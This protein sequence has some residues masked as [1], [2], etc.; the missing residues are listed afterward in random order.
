[1]TARKAKQDKARR[2]RV[3][4]VDCGELLYMTEDGEREALR[5]GEWIEFRRK[6]T[7][8]D[9]Q[10]VLRFSE[11]G[12]GGNAALITELGDLCKFLAGK[13]SAWNWTDLDADEPTA[14]PEKPTADILMEMD[15]DDILHITNLYMSLVEPSKN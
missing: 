15:I 14:Y 9:L 5:V 6:Q 13:I 10:T 8:A 11:L 1:M 12:E 2:R 4:R 7:P 3:V